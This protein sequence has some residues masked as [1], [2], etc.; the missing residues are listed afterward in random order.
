MKEYRLVLNQYVKGEL[1]KQIIVTAE[2]EV[3]A[4]KSLGLDNGHNFV[5]VEYTDKK[6]EKKDHVIK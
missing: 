2:N 3:D 4:L 5:E 6:G 1:L